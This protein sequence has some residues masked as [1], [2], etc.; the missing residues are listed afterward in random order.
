VNLAA[1]AV[2]AHRSPPPTPTSV[3]RAGR[4]DDLTIE[5]LPGVLIPVDQIVA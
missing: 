4:S 3:A 1:E 5:T 2:E